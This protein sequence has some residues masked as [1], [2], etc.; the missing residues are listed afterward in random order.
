MFDAQFFNERVQN[1]KFLRTVGLGV[2]VKILAFSFLA[3]LAISPV[4]TVAQ[5]VLPDIARDC[6]A[7]WGSDYEMQLYCREKQ[8]EAYN[9]LNR[10]MPER[11]RIG[12]LTT[13]EIY[14]IKRY[15][16]T[17]DSAIQEALKIN[18]RGG[19]TQLNSSVD[20]CYKDANN[21]DNMAYCIT[22]DNFA[23]ILNGDKA[24]FRNSVVD[25]A[26]RVVTNGRR[27]YG[28]QAPDMAQALSEMGVPRSL[29]ALKTER[30]R[31]N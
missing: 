11:S 8:M 26:I 2:L 15:S 31:A 24:S 7:K 5:E 22:L 25:T 10:H 14:L 20:K 4:E 12:E 13:N 9:K 28:N 16:E 6:E 17:I 30:S 1:C 27:F 21:K 18:R 3:V 29:S 19:L 23:A